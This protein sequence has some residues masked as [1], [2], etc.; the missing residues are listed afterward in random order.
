MDRRFYG[1]HLH[2][3][4]EAPGR[5]PTRGHASDPNRTIR[6]E[7]AAVSEPNRQPISDTRTYRRKRSRLPALGDQTREHESRNEREPR[8]AILEM[9][10]STDAYRT[11]DPHRRTHKASAPSPS[12]Q[13]LSTNCSSSRAGRLTITGPTRGASASWD[14][15]RSRAS[16]RRPEESTPQSSTRANAHRGQCCAHWRPAPG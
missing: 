6:S 13:R 15:A 8:A 5:A 2:H 1:Y 14:V 3:S 16:S 12:S 9:R 7:S 10:S 4:A 11:G